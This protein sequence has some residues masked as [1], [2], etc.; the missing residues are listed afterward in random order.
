[1]YIIKQGTLDVW[2]TPNKLVM[3]NSEPVLLAKLQVG[4]VVGELSLLDGAARSADLRA[5][6]D[7]AT[8]LAL[9]DMALAKLAEDDPAMG[10]QIM[11]NLA[12]SLGKRLRLQNWRAARA[13]ER[14]LQRAS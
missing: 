1:M 6:D 8:L 2:L 12:I 11:K 13:T 5:G 9:N 4:Q 10:M 3:S 14:A 7:G